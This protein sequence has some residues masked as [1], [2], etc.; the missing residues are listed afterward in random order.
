M[1]GGTLMTDDWEHTSP[2]GPLGWLAD[3]LVLGRHMRRLLET[4]N[5]A[6]KAAAE[7]EDPA[8]AT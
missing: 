8:T 1:A 7:A 4:R 5:A 2:L 6:L 3:R